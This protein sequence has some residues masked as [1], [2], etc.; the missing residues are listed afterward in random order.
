MAIIDVILHPVETRAM[1][2]Y[3]LWREPLH[4]RQPE[5]ETPSLR[6][7]YY[8]LDMTSRSF[9]AVI[10]EL[11]PELRDAVMIFYLVLRGLDT[12]EDDMTLSLE[13]K[14]PLLK[15]FYQ[16]ISQEGWCFKE[17]GEKEK[18]RQLLVEFDVVVE[19]FNKLKPIYREVI[20]DICK[21]MGEGMAYYSDESISVNTLADFDK[22]C[23]YVAGLVGEGLSKL[24]ANSGLENKRY[25]ELM[26]LSNSMGLFLQKTNIIRDYREDLDDGRIFWPRDIWSKYATDIADLAKPENSEAAL[27][28]ISEMTCNALEHSIDVLSYL[29]GLKNQSVFNFCAIPQAMAI[30]TLALV[31]R[32]P[33]VFQRNVK[34]RK[35][36]ACQ[37]INRSTNLKYVSEIFINNIRLIHSK[38]SPSDPN[39]LR[40]SILCGRLEQWVNDVFPPL[41]ATIEPPKTP[42]QEQIDKD[43]QMVV[44]YVVLFWTG[45]GGI[46]LVIA[47]FLGARYDVALNSLMAHKGNVEL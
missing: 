44:L 36:Q 38:N 17:N 42:Q 14:L 21:E 11:S 27:N 20:T 39:F 23:H 1:V 2:Q 29:S 34:I 40:V 46:L 28:C 19:E 33:Q 30:A 24:F 32:N 6:R 47:Y 9:S 26:E 18:D 43:L 13:R 12:I 16:V 3:R 10:Q 41:Q 7:C 35:G 37:M 8:F 5:R 45:M 31:F 22:Y 25:A 15:S 4:A